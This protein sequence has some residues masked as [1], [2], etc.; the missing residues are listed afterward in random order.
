MNKT[1]LNWLDIEDE[2]VVKKLKKMSEKGIERN[3]SSSL[4][5]GTGGIR[6]KMELGT[7]TVNEI[8][9]VKFAFAFLKFLG[10]KK[11]KIVIA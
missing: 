7:N 2:N 5:F 4:S 1:Y 6:G 3:F 11:A 9:V 8:V 10:N